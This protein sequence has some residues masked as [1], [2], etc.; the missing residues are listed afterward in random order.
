MKIVYDIVEHN[1]IE[2]EMCFSVLKKGAM[3]SL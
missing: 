1:D 3:S 2:G